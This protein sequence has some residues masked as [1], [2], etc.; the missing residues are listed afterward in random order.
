M[1]PK[2]V[3]K[4]FN[5]IYDLADQALREWPPTPKAG[6]VVDGVKVLE[7]TASRTRLREMWALCGW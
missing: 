4:L 2:R 5:R 6:Q 1:Q 3:R 7:R